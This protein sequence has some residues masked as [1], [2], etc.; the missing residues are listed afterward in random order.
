MRAYELMVI[1]DPSLDERTIE[2]TLDKYLKIVREDGGSIDEVDIWGRRRL[3]YEIAKNT[4]GIYAVVTLTAEPA[5]VKELDRQLG[6]NE[7]IL[8]TKVIRPGAR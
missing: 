6:L 3:A 1:A 5:T 4:E 7:S 8:R 2:P